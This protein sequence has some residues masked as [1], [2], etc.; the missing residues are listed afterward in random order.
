MDEPEKMQVFEMCE[1]LCI[2]SHHPCNY[3]NSAPD[4]LHINVIKSDY[5]RLKEVLLC[6]RQRPIVSELESLQRWALSVYVCK[7]YTAVSD[8][9]SILLSHCPSQFSHQGCRE[10]HFWLVQ[11]EE[12]GTDLYQARNSLRKNGLV[13]GQNTHVYSDKE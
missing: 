2:T 4:D 10:I 7:P 11:W 3:T 5:S 1:F 8:Q 13:L 12:V 6:L 9:V